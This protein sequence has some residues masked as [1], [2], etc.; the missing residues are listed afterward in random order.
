MLND[1]LKYWVVLAAFPKEET[2]PRDHVASTKL[3]SFQL[4]GAV[5]P[6]RYLYSVSI[7]ETT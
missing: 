4:A 1:L 2:R 5:L 3:T 7:G 6:L